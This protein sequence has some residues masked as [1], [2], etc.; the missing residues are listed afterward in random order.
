LLAYVF[1]R[2]Q[3]EVFLQLKGLLEPFGI[4]HYDTDG[5]G[6]YE[7]HLDAAQH[8]VGKDSTEKI[9]SKHIDCAANFGVST[10]W[11]SQPRLSG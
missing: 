2:R 9:E 11:L 7:R 10:N 6:A 8:R 1:G 5:W 4:T 3:D